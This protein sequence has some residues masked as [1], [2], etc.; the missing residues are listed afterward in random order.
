MGILYLLVVATVVYLVIGSAIAVIAGG[1]NCLPPWLDKEKHDD[2]IIGF[3]WMSRNL[4]ARSLVEPPV[5][6]LGTGGQDCASARNGK[7]GPSPAP[8][9]GNGSSVRCRL[10][11]D[12]GFSCHTLPSQQ[13]SST[14]ALVF[15]GTMWTTTL[16][17]IV[18]LSRS[19]IF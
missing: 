16:R 13:D 15:D 1:H 3:S 11:Q 5:M 14:S 19:K 7:M 8:R 6:I 18:C 4:T 9:L 10:G 17:W 12:H 2:R